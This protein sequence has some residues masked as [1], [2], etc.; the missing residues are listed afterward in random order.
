MP[1]IKTRKAAAKRF[2]VNSNGTIKH[3]HCNKN[4]ILAKK[5]RKR[6]RYL[7]STGYVNQADAKNVKAM[8]GQK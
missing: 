5:T 3:A 6:K 1:K 8:L 2:T 4:H 7:R